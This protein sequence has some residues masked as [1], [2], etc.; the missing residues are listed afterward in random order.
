MEGKNEEKL[1]KRICKMP[2]KELDSKMFKEM[3]G[4]LHKFQKLKKRK[5][6]IWIENV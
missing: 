5:L 1:G 6:V 3:K 4:I 2:R